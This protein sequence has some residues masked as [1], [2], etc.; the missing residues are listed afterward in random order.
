MHYIVGGKE[1][2]KKVTFFF[3]GAGL[4]ALPLQVHASPNDYFWNPN[5]EQESE[6]ETSDESWDELWGEAQEEAEQAN[7]DNRT[8]EE[9]LDDFDQQWAA[10]GSDNTNN[11]FGLLSGEINNFGAFQPLWSSI[12]NSPE[13]N[14]DSE[15]DNG[16]NVESPESPQSYSNDDVEQES[17]SFD[18]KWS[19]F[20]EKFDSTYDNEGEDSNSYEWEESFDGSTGTYERS[21]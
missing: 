6:V 14:E 16:M 9:R 12:F 5:A 18:D 7:E 21:N 8:E 15:T 19:Q 20:G 3:L 10:F 2:L 1:A 11:S 13:E 4:L 17:S